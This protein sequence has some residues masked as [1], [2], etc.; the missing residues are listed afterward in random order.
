[1]LGFVINVSQL[2]KMLGKSVKQTTKDVIEGLG[3][4]G[5]KPSIKIVVDPAIHGKNCFCI[6]G[7]YE[8]NE[9]WAGDYSWFHHSDALQCTFK[10]LQPIKY[11]LNFKNI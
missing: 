2:S 7:N 4:K 9:L 8:T 11:Q 5:F 10:E 3:K 1:M 6:Y